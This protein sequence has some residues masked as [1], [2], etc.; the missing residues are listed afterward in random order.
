MTAADITETG[1]V[2]QTTVP[3]WQPQLPPPLSSI[4]VHRE[5]QFT[6]GIYSLEAWSAHGNADILSAPAGSGGEG[7]GITCHQCEMH[8]VHTLLFSHFFPQQV[9]FQRRQSQR[10]DT[11]R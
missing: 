11:Q 10:N 1:R 2:C 9:I 3:R 5:L 4:R 7:G 8:Y 6:A